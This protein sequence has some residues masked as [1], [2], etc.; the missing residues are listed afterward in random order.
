MRKALIVSTA[1]TP[2]GKS[3]RGAFNNTTSPALGG[4]AIKHAV[5]RARIDPSEV[6]DV[7][8]DAAGL[9]AAVR[10]INFIM[11]VCSTVCRMTAIVT[12]PRI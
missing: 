4:H 8:M 9:F 5:E 12:V 1:R 7:I 2:T 3:C 6:G 11:C 10:D